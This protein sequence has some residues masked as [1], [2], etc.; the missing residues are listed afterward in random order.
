M[1]AVEHQQDAL[2]LNGSCLNAGSGKKLSKSHVIVVLVGQRKLGRFLAGL[3]R[4][5]RRG[6]AAP[7]E[8][9]ESEKHNGEQ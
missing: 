2:G 6:G 9:S 5:G 8:D 1:A 3:R 7:V 4:G